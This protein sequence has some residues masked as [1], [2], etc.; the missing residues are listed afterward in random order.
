[1][2]D[3]QVMSDRIA[4]EIEDAEK[5]IRDAMNNLDR[6]PDDADMYRKLS[7]DELNHADI[8][9]TAVV[10]KIKKWKEDTGKE[11]PPDMQARYD[12]LHQEHMKKANKVKLMIQVYKQDAMK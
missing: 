1:M 3:I 12:V 5:Y 8:L 9:H 7:E 6:N 10:K 2:V 11:V 4:E